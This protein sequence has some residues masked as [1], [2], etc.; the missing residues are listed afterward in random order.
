MTFFLPDRFLFRAL[1]ITVLHKLREDRKI[2]LREREGYLVFLCPR[3]I[4]KFG[5]DVVVHGVITSWPFLFPGSAGRSPSRGSRCGTIRNRAYSHA[6]GR[7]GNSAAR[8]GWNT[9]VFF[10]LRAMTD[11]FAILFVF[12]LPLRLPFGAGAPFFIGTPN[13]A[14]FATDFIAVAHFAARRSRRSRTT[15]ATSPARSPGTPGG[16]GRPR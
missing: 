15:P 10:L 5:K 8:C 16:R 12:F 2:H 1:D 13:S 9:S 7:S 11:S 14:N 4:F 3:G 6:C